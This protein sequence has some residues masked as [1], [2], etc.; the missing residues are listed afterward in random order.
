MSAKPHLNLVIIGHVD[1]GKSTLVGRLLVEIGAIDEKTWKETVEAAKKAGKESEKYAWLLDR[2]KEERERGLTISLAYRKFETDNYYYTIIDAPGHR[3][4]VKNMITGASQ[5]DVAL[6]VVSAKKGDFEAGMSP[7]GQTR[8]HI[9]LARTMGIDQLIIAITKM[10]TTEPPYSEKRFIEVLETLIKFLRISGYKLDTITV[11]PVSG[12]V[13]DN[14]I[15]Y[16]E[17]MSWWNNQKIE[18]IRKK[19]GVN[20]ARTLLEALN[21]VKVPP[22]PID[23][24]L[25]IPIS[26]VFVISGVGTVPVGRVET[27]KLKVGDTVIFMPPNVTGEV[28]S[29]EMHHQR[30]EEAIP[31]DNIGFNVRGISKEQ[32]RR[33][34]VAGHPTNPPTVIDEFTARVMVVWHPTAI[35]PGY[36]PVIHAHT[37]SIPCRIVEI[38]ARL[39]PRTGQIAEKNPPFLKQGDIAIV[40]FKP[41]KPMVAEKYSDFPPLGRFAMRDM[42]KTVGIGIIMDLK[43][44]KVGGK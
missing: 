31:G 12:W 9:L 19:Y 42:G 27:G 26:E 7:E 33:G 13:G 39:D 2:L 11:L 3:D 40:R 16:S 1:H 10:D 17:N 29:I 23:K 41:L 24:P 20:G 4:F 34:D 25:R 32:V 44:A 18:E 6:L 14:V 36:T 5:A 30:L 28:R 8:E 22:K 38:I 35:A 43:P 37:A 21:N 15:K